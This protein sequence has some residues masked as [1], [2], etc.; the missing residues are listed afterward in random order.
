MFYI[1]PNLFKVNDKDNFK[2]PFR[3][4]DVFIVNFI[5]IQFNII[6]IIYIIYI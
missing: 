3:S 5:H 2:M 4:F 6:Y 1:A